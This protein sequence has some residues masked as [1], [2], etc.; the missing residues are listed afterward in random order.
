ME[1]SGTVADGHLNVFQFHDF[2]NL[3]LF[4]MLS[5]SAIANTVTVL[6]SCLGAFSCTVVAC[7]F[8]YFAFS[9]RIQSHW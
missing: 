5:A 9:F 6:V 8:S 7:C 2:V 3:S 1:I 4:V